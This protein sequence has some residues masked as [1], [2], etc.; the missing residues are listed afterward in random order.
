MFTA[1]IPGLNGHKSINSQTA[2]PLPSSNYY[3]V[4]KASDDLGVPCFRL[5]FQT[6]ANP[7]PTLSQMGL[8]VAQ[9]I[10][11]LQDEYGDEGLIVASSIG[12]G[13]AFQAMSE[14]DPGYDFPGLIAFKPVVDPLNAISAALDRLP[15][16]QGAVLLQ[17]LKAEEIPALPI[18]VEA[19]S[20]NEDPGH[21]L[22]T[23]AH[24]DDAAALRLISDT[25]SF[26]LFES[27]M[28]GRKMP[29]LEFILAEDDKTA[30]ENINSFSTAVA[31][32][33][34]RGSMT[35]W[36]SGTHSDNQSEALANAVTNHLLTLA[37]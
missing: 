24:L 35:S 15:N 36:V 31:K 13:V 12:T 23:K 18:P 10:E 1:F 26:A 30:S 2:E 25:T 7:Y 6:A 22:L 37:R 11:D 5:I 29:L 8:I 19:S 21:F 33:S 3:A 16:A 17:K 4:K 28:D 14:L 20:I 27:K 9:Q 34:S 32:W